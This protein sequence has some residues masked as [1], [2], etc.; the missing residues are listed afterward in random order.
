MG[1]GPAFPREGMGFLSPSLNRPPFVPTPLFPD[2]QSIVPDSPILLT[3]K[4][5]DP[6]LGAKVSFTV[7]VDTRSPPVAMQASGIADTALE[8][9]GLELGQRYYWKVIASD[10]IDRTESPVRTFFLKARV[11]VA[12]SEAAK[13]VA[14]I[15]FIL[16]PKGSYHRDDGSTVQ[17]GPFFLDKTEVTQGQ[18]QKVVGKN[19]S[20]RFHDSLPVERVTWEEAEGYCQ[21]TGGRLPTEAEWEYAARAGD[22][23]NYYGGDKHRGEYAWYRENSNNQSQ[24]VGLKKPNAWGLHD[25]SGNVFEWVQDWYADYA[26]QDVDHPKGPA[27]GTAKVIRGASWYSEA[28]NL[29]LSAR[30]N[31]RPGFRNFK[32]GFRCA[33]DVHGPVLGESAGSQAEAFVS[34]RSGPPILP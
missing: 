25:M 8:L 1:I 27:T 34:K 26:P 18:F 6:D 5:G 28:P 17:V 31:N 22:S 11:P 14:D 30:Y 3:W 32:V 33:K 23:N 2:S 20:Y 24:K 12:K 7:L 19:P 13:K 16:V 29:E 9:A 21:E 4:G 10:G 15:P